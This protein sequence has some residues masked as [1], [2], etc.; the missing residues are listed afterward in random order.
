MI[1]SD[2]EI[3]AAQA[4][5]ALGIWQEPRPEAW[6]SMA[7]DLTLD[8]HLSLWQGPG[9]HGPRLRLRPHSPEYDFTVVAAQMSREILIPAEGYVLETGQFVLGWTAEKVWFPHGSRLAARVEGKSGLAR[10]GLGIHVTAP[11]IHAGFGAGRGDS[12]SPGS[13]IRLEIWNIGPFELVLDKGMP[14]CQLIIEWVDGTP[15]KGYHGQFTAQG[16]PLAAPPGRAVPRGKL[17]RRGKK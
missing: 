13:P 4:R 3:R 8:E 17:A 11:T 6:S 9:P 2:R 12:G 7:V 10:L 15:E 5:G 1:L 14:I 16:P